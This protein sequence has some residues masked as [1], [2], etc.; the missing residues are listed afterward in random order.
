MVGLSRIHTRLDGGGYLECCG[1]F[2]FSGLPITSFVLGD[3]LDG[4]HDDND[5][6][7]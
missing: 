1:S 3:S 2:S 6:G 7:T 4:L 5:G